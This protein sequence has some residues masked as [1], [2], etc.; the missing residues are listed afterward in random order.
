MASSVGKGFVVLEY[1]TPEPVF[2]D[3]V[4]YEHT[5]S[6]LMQI[7]NEIQRSQA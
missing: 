6:L 2:K 4:F 5:D 3:S 7:K 1:V